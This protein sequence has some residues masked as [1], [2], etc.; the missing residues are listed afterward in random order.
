[1]VILV[2][3]P[4]NTGLVAI[5]PPIKMPIGKKYTLLN[6]QKVWISLLSRK[7]LAVKILTTINSNKIT[8]AEFSQ[9]GVA[10]NWPVPITTNPTIK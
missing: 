6:D 3:S 2:A 1:M 9:S 10:K 8:K 5:S 7:N 4:A